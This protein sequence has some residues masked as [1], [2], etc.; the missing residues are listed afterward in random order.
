MSKATPAWFQ[1][2]LKDNPQA[3]SLVKQ[4]IRARIVDSLQIPYRNNELV[5]RVAARR[6][7]TGFTTYTYPQYIVEAFHYLLGRELD[8]VVEGQTKRLMIW[9][10]P[11]HGKSELVSVRLPAYWLGQRPDEPVILSSYGASLAESKSRM[12]RGI[13]ESDAFGRLFPGVKTVY[14]SRSVQRW[15]V[16]GRRGSMLAVGVGGPITGHGARLGIIDDP[17]SSWERAQ[18]EWAR[19]RVWDWYRATFRTRIWEDGV[20]VII[21]TRWHEDDLC[22]KILQEQ[23]DK[24]RVLRFPAL[25]ESQRDREENNKF[26]GLPVGAPDLLGREAGEPLCPA[27]FSLAA[28][29]DIKEDVGEAAWSAEYQG[30]PRPTEGNMFKRHWFPIV[31]AAPLEAERVRYWD[32]AATEGGGD[33]CVGLLMARSKA[34]LYFVEDV[35]RGQWSSHQVDQMMLQTAILDAEKYDGRVT[36]WFEQEGGS[37]GKDSAGATIRLLAGYAVYAEHPSGSK[38][39]RAKPLQAQAEAGNV[40]L[41]RGA[42]NAAYLNEITAFPSG[43]HDDQVDTSS[44]AFNRLAETSRRAVGSSRVVQVVGL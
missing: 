43:R 3:A 19:E 20:I 21:M 17:F 34:G 40:R 11:Q 9:A 15:E 8:R 13:V 38:E 32:R 1:Q 18:S 23:A 28:L 2:W 41:V 7:L 14:N 42:W 5:E 26:L 16:R 10:P 37:A 24:W 25:A 27:R 33:W 30:V 12:A 4:Q 31:D 44:G 6:S 35:V 29:R 22:G 39:V 36:I